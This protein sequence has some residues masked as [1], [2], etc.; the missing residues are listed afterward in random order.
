M[1]IGEEDD[2]DR[3]PV[4]ELK[5]LTQK[6]RNQHCEK[7]LTKKPKLLSRKKLN[8]QLYIIDKI[9]KGEFVVEEQ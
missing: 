5:H 4:K 6:L 8:N 2:S 7:M 9:K 1:S 3:M